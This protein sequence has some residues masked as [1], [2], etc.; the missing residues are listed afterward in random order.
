FG[1]KLEKDA[2]PV[3]WATL[4]G[5]VLIIFVEWWLKGRPLADRINWPV[6]VTVGF[7]QLVAAAFPGSSRSGVTILAALALGV[8]R[9]LATEFSFLVG[10]PTLISAAGYQVYL[11]HKEAVSIDWGLVMVGFAAAAVTAFVAVKW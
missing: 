8:N 7:A 10:I 4:I 1:L 3:A 11:A 6:A 9:P 2:V 5:G